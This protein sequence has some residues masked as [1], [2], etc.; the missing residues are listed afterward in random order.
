MVREPIKSV[1]EAVRVIY[2]NH[3]GPEQLSIFHRKTTN[4]WEAKIG[5][6]GTN[7]S[8]PLDAVRMLAEHMRQD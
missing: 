3:E 2:E 7:A 8:D 5:T 1:D 4:D 6:T